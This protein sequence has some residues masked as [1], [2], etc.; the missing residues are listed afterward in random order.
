MEDTNKVFDPNTPESL[1][2]AFNDALAPRAT[3]RRHTRPFA[4]L[5]A[6]GRK[7]SA[8]PAS[9]PP[10]SHGYAGEGAGLLTLP[11]SGAGSGKG[12][13][14]SQGP[15]LKLLACQD[16]EQCADR[17]PA[18]RCRP[19]TGRQGRSRRVAATASSTRS[20]HPC[21]SP[22]TRCV[23]ADEPKADQQHHVSDDQ[24]HADEADDGRQ[25]D[26][27]GERVRDDRLCG[28]RNGCE[29]RDRVHRVRGTFTACLWPAISGTHRG[30]Y[31]FAACVSCSGISA[32]PAR[33][34][35]AIKALAQGPHA[36]ATPTSMRPEASRFRNNNA[37]PVRHYDLLSDVGA[38]TT[39]PSFTGSVAP[40][41]R[42]VRTTPFLPS[43]R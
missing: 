27:C 41:L 11:S 23:G 39:C 13:S 3:A 30:R 35:V 19:I 10:L 12:G 28:A 5:K 7:W 18:W 43:R 1:D 4:T 24:Q 15:S 29:H 31:G 20:R 6:A 42:N 8:H 21:A 34:R 14:S 16:S 33:L 40:G 37:L 26:E 25:A 17:H 2:V 38:A 9:H 22:A 32:T 36:R